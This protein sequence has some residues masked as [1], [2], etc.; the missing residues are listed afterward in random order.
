MDD[1]K[2]GDKKSLNSEKSIQKKKYEK[3]EIITEGLNTYGAV[4]N[5]T[6]KGG[7][8][9]TTAPPTPCNAN[10]LNS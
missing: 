3:P 10:R 2:T 8:K 6:T 1:Q 7:R 5:G 4:C 9:S